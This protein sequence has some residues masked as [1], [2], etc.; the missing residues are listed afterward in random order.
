MSQFQI[1]LQFFFF[2]IKR[3]GFQRDKFSHLLVSVWDV[4]KYNCSNAQAHVSDFSHV[5]KN[6]HPSLPLLQPQG[7]SSPASRHSLSHSSW[8]TGTATSGQKVSQCPLM[9]VTCVR[10]GGTA[11]SCSTTASPA[12]HK[13]WLN[14][15]CG[16]G[17][18]VEKGF[19]SACLGIA[20]YLTVGSTSI[21][22]MLCLSWFAQFPV[23]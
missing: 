22:K 18:L 2:F 8:A 4:L 14:W 17:R 15:F 9:R 1:L 6:F 12:S 19:S 11:L 16:E 10:A 7:L 23:L 3:L 5:Q 13:S 20:L 21:L